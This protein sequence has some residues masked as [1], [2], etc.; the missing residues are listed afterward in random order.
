MTKELIGWMYLLSTV[1]SGW[2][3]G[4]KIRGYVLV[5]LNYLDHKM[6]GRVS[7]DRDL[8]FYIKILGV[9]KKRVQLQQL[10]TLHK[11]AYESRLVCVL[12]PSQWPIR[13]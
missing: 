10:M 11:R 4:Q 12:A 6:K 5:Q 1:V 8:A 9:A 7:R 2:L 13:R 3:R